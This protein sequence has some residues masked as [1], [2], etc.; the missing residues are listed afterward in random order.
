MNMQRTAPLRTDVFP[1]SELSGE[2]AILELLQCQE[3]EKNISTAACKPISAR[4]RN[5]NLLRL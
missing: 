3:G 2:W 4:L 5:I 1:T